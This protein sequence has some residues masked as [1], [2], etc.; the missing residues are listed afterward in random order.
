MAFWAADA[1]GIVLGGGGIVIS[2]W[3]GVL[4]QSQPRRAIIINLYVEREYRQQGI[5]LQLMNTMI[6]WCRQNEFVS[7]S[8][9]ASDEGRSL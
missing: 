7:V 5:A 8:L 6:S 1:E 9:H 3:P 4:G 2:P